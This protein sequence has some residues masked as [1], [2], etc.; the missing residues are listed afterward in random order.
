MR[1]REKTWL[2]TWTVVLVLGA[3]LGL[4]SAAMVNS[5]LPGF[6]HFYRGVYL[7][8]PTRTYQGYLSVD[9][10]GVYHYVTA[11]PLCRNQY[12][13]CFDSDEV[14]FY[15]GTTN[16]TIRLIF[17]C[18]LDY[19]SEASQLPFGDGAHI[20]VKGTLIQ[21]S[22]WPT[23]KFKPSLNF[24]GDLYVFQNRTLSN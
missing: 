22:A 9:Y 13:P 18:G 1:K 8:S 21:P 17:Y 5:R 24:E 6:E 16:G 3:T 20:Y 19:C 15:L 2:G 23:T 14:V 10:E 12:P 4:V 7:R 11:K